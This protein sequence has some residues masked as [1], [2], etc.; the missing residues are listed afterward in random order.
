ML[1]RLSLVEPNVEACEAYRTVT[2]GMDIN[3]EWSNSL[4]D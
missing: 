1:L 3:Q 4:S 2:E